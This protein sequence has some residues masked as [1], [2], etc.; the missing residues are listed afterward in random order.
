M[1]DL[2][3]MVLVKRI[4]DGDVNLFSVLLKRYERPVHSLIQQIIPSREDAEELT[5]DVFIKAFRSL[6]SF[7]GGCSFSTWLYRIAYNAAISAT[8]K[9]K[10]TFPAFD[11]NL[12]NEIPDE[13]VDL[14]LDSDED[15]ELIRKLEQAIELLEIEEKILISLYYTEEKSIS[16]ISTILQ[17]SPENVK[18]RLFRIR[19]K[20][21]IL[22]NNGKYES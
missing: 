22:I 13:T 8:R 21:V 9:R 2:D 1:E 17:I 19:K 4:I 7:R 6:N 11:E 12:L 20:I 5:E 16:E 14:L 3:E 18:I 10:I 15:E